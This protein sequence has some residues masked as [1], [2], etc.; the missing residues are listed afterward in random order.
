[1]IYGLLIGVYKFFNGGTKSFS[2]NNLDE[3]EM[4][5]FKF[6]S[7]FKGNFRLFFKVL[8]EAFRYSLLL[9]NYGKAVEFF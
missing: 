8:G 4:W 9:A 6:I 1:L 7:P 5:K 3:C 2:L